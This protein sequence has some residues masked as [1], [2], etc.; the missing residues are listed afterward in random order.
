[1]A[2]N[3]NQRVPNLFFLGVQKGG[4]TLWY[5]HLKDHPNI[6]LPK[7]KEPQFFTKDELYN[8]GL[9]AYLEFYSEA[10]DEKYLGDF[11]PEYIFRP[12]AIRRLTKYNSQQTKYI[13][14]LRQPIDRAYSQYNMMLS[15]G[16]SMNDFLTDLE[17]D[18][19][20][21]EEPQYINALRPAYLVARGNYAQQIEYLLQFIDKEQLKV[22]F[23]EEWISE[24]EAYLN[25]IVDFLEIEGHNLVIKDDKDQNQTLLFQQNKITSSIKSV[26][27]RILR[28]AFAESPVYKKGK[29]LIKEIMG[30]KPEKLSADLRR[31]LTQKYY[32]EEIAKLELILDKDLSFW[33]K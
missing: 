8:K 29:K 16:F 3:P 18:P 1:M 5:N 26:N 2:D 27:K 25:E 9:G 22:I 19:K 6:F 4:T 10:K 24:Q 32:Q 12:K 23:F 17:S 31:E 7:N 30:S 11:S 33:R 28:S 14:S 15:R 13:L 20:S 21:I